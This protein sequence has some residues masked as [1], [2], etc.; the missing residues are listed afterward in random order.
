MPKVD[1]F[2]SEIQIKREKYQGREMDNLN[3]HCLERQ[4]IRDQSQDRND[5]Q[6]SRKCDCDERLKNPEFTGYF[7]GQANINTGKV[8][9][10]YY[11]IHAKVT[12]E[13]LP[14][15]QALD[16]TSLLNQRIQNR[17][18]VPPLTNHYLAYRETPSA[19]APRMA[20]PHL[21][22]REGKSGS[23]SDIIL[24][25]QNMPNS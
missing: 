22:S 18:Q 15:N 3:T 21:E 25:T 10:H 2:S 8:A 19:L 9:G 1:E 12:F 23:V 13:N 14:C 4:A 6:R 11:N 7:Y 5:D 24:N 20:K 16:K 17:S